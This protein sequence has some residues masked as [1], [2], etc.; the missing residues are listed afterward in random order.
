MAYR[1][2]I[3]TL[4]GGRDF[5]LPDIS[6]GV[7][8]SDEKIWSADTGRNVKGKMVGTIIAIKKTISLTWNSMRPSE[9]DAL[10][11]YLSNKN[12][13]F[14]TI[15]LEGYNGAGTYT[16]YFSSPT[17]EHRR[18]NYGASNGGNLYFYTG[19]SVEFVEQ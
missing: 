3:G 10:E 2:N 7:S 17:Y 14:A 8:V 15:T 18:G 6:G 19:V 4:V 13:P 1:C 9:Y 12:R 11:A 16:G 5:P